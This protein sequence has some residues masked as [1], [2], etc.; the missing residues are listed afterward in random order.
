[1][2]QD[3]RNK[4]TPLLAYPMLKIFDFLILMMIKTNKI[5]FLDTPKLILLKT[6][7]QIQSLFLLLL[8]IC[9][10]NDSLNI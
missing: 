10:A 6:L 3:Y 2:K 8:S 7:Y 9:S 4:Q 5:L 1:M